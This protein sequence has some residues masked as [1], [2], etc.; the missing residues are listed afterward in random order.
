M[1]TMKEI[2]LAKK[3]E[4]RYRKVRRWV[5]SPTFQFAWKKC[6]NKERILK[7]IEDGDIDN[8][9]EWAYFNN[10][11]IDAPSRWLKTQANK[12]GI[13]NYSRKTKMELVNDLSGIIEQLIKQNETDTKSSRGTRS[14]T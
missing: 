4:S 6:K 9:R 12:Q 13:P 1:D 5:V 11:L 14:S 10:P 7:L 8:L 2:K 3:L